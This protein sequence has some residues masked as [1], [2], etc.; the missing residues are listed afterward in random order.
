MHPALTL[1]IALLM[2]SVH[3]FSARLSFLDSTPRS[4]WLSA[5]GGVSVAYVL[6]HLLPELSEHQRNLTSQGVGHVLSAERHVYIF[7]LA[8]LIVFY[9]LERLARSHARRS[10]EADR[11]GDVSP[12]FLLHI[13]SFGIYNLLIGYL[14]VHREDPSLRGLA[15]YA[16]AMILHFIVN[17]RGLSETY[18]NG[19]RMSRWWLAAAPVAGWLLGAMTEVPI[20]V[21]STLFAFLAGGVILNVLKEELPEERESRFSAFLVG[22]AVYAALLLVT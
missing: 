12:V 14:L 16:I 13:G 17:D 19:Y 9:G 2:A 11:R 22:A 18:K 21:I 20:L 10:R 1:I 7:A 8:G 6:V 3:A 4:R 15:F 5:A